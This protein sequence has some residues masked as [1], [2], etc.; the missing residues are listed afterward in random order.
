MFFVPSYVGHKNVA[1]LFTS[2]DMI[3][4]AFVGWVSQS[5]NVKYNWRIL[6]VKFT[7][8]FHGYHSHHWNK[9]RYN[10]TPYAI[11]PLMWDSNVPWIG[12]KYNFNFFCL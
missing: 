7:N 9:C 5:N 3:I 8:G 12:G 1:R 11:T 4:I 10:E 6:G 2:Y